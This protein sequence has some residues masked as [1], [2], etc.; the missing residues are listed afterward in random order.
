[1]KKLEYNVNSL[2]AIKEFLKNY[3]YIRV[4]GEEYENIEEFKRKLLLFRKGFSPFKTVVDYPPLY[5]VIDKI[6]NGSPIEKDNFYTLYLK[7]STEEELYTF[8]DKKMNNINFEE[9]NNLHD[10]ALES[11]KVVKEE[12]KGLLRRLTKNKKID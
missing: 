8:L 6:I 7:N 11:I 12:K 1:M 5:Y 10:K 2:L 3:K 4:V 9:L